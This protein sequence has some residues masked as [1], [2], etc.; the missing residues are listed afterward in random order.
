MIA[1]CLLLLHPE[2]IQAPIIADIMPNTQ[3]ITIPAVAP[4]DNEM[5]WGDEDNEGGTNEVEDVGIGAV[6]V[7]VVVVGEEIM[8]KPLT[9]MP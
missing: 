3:A 7:A 1:A 2:T 9:Y 6:D 4:F 5:E 8:L